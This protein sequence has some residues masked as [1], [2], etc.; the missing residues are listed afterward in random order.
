M[1]A[2][3]LAG[4]LGTAL[5]FALGATGFFAL[6]ARGLGRSF[7]WPQAALV[8]STLFVVALGLHPFPDIDSLD[9]RDGGVRKLLRPFDYWQYYVQFWED[10]YL[11]RDWLSSPAI[12]AP[13]MN[14]VLFVPIGLALGLLTRSWGVA[15]LYAVGVTLFIEL[16]QVSALYGIYPCPYRHFEVDDLTHN[17]AGILL[18]FWLMRRRGGP[19]VAQRR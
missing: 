18:G 6:L 3:E 19:Y 13:L 7:G 8:A 4:Y 14:I 16:S 1:T 5:A 2:G 12:M 11:L 17:T 9:C 10:G 15:A